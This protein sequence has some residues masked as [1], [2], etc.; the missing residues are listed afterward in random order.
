MTEKM[1]NVYPNIHAKIEFCQLRRA[2]NETM[3]LVHWSIRLGNDLKKDG[4][5]DHLDHLA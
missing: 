2:M 5:L 3:E 1:S 4:H